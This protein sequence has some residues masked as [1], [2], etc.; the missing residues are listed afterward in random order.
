MHEPEPCE[1]PA[2]ES[3]EPTHS[4]A[5]QHEISNGFLAP[6]FEDPKQ[7]RASQ[8]ADQAGDR[9]VDA[10]IREPGS[11]QLAS[12]HPQ[13]DHGTHSDENAKAGDLESTDAEEDGIH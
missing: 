8:P 4:A 5:A 9:G 2:C 11:P 3:A 1:N 6:M 12:E 7:L 13:A 10:G